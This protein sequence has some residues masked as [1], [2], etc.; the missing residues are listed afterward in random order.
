MAGAKAPHIIYPCKMVDARRLDI[1]ILLRHAGD[2]G[3]AS[4]GM[5]DLMAKPHKPKLGIV[6]KK[7]AY[8]GFGIG[9]VN[10]EG[11]GRQSLHI[12]PYSLH[13]LYIAKGM[14]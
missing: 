6:G 4:I 7:C 2:P 13:H 12:I 11:M 8:T 14:A 3:N 1:Q 10:L 9:K 5:I